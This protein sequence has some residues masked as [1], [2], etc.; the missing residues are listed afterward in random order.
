LLTF[1]VLSESPKTSFWPGDSEEFIEI[2]FRS[3]KNRLIQCINLFSIG[4]GKDFVSIWIFLYQSIPN[5]ALV[6]SCWYKQWFFPFR[7]LSFISRHQRGFLLYIWF[8]VLLP[9]SL[10]LTD[11]NWISVN[12][13]ESPGQKLVL[14]LS[15]STSNVSNYITRL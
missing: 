5:T 8:N 3:V 11:L 2:Q 1:K 9:M 13:S 12:F 6:G 7:K 15:E 4:F 10:F 14:G